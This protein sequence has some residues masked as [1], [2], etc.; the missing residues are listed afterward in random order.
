M[1]GEEV[2]T[3]GKCSELIDKVS[4]LAEKELNV[5]GSR[6]QVGGAEIY[7]VTIGLGGIAAVVGVACEES[8]GL[9]ASASLFYSNI[10][11]SVDALEWL[12][13]YNYHSPGYWLLV[14]EG[15]EKVLTY[16]VTPSDSWDPEA[17]LVALTYAAKALVDAASI[18]GVEE[19]EG[20]AGSGEE[21]GVES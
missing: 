19:G 9:S 14:D 1:A 6:T 11:R 7:S 4:R 2:K 8:S 21:K 5:K 3:K 13:A 16:M 10:K 17:A 15:G 12:L 18:L 20:K